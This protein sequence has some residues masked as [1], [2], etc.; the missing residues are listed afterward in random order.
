MLDSHIE[1]EQ[2]S[3]S[4]TYMPSDLF[5]RM[6]HIAF[7]HMGGMKDLPAFP[8]VQGLHKLTY[9]AMASASSM[10]ALPALHDLPRLA[11]LIIVEAA[12]VAVLPSFAA[13]TNLKSFT[14]SNRN[15][16]CCNGYVT[17]TCDLS[18]YQCK[19]R[20]D[21]PPVGCVTERM[22]TADWAVLD[23]ANSLVCSKNLTV[24]VKSAAPTAQTSDG[25]CGGVLYRQCAMNGRGGI[26]YNARMQVIACDVRGYY[27]KLR[28]LEIARGIG[29]KCNYTEEAWLGCPKL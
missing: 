23:K 21:E 20:V 8:R 11:Q 6:H 17:G 29:N 25:L 28:R 1:C 2:P 9:L 18:E 13:L 3:T 24:D 5:E 7:I 26:C 15:A 10:Q 27:E 12:H 4:L 16:A 19:P 22:S 14:L